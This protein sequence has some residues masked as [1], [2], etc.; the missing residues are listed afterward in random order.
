MKWF[1]FL[2]LLLS[3]CSQDP[4]AALKRAEFYQGKPQKLAE[5][6]DGT[7]L[8]KV[9]DKEKSQTVYFSTSGTQW[10]ERVG[11]TTREHRVANRGRR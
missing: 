5:T 3:A 1:V 11:K 7:I 8:W 2:F 6:P 10:D 9:W 4:E